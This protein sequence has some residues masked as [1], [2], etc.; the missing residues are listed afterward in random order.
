MSTQVMPDIA[1]TDSF[2]PVSI[3]RL[4]GSA[5]VFEYERY[6]SGRCQLTVDGGK[7]GDRITL[8]HSPVRN[9]SVTGPVDVD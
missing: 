3:T 8:I 5:V 1:V 9:P 4:A 2:R 7:R 6:M